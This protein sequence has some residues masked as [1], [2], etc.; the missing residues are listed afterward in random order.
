MMARIGY[1]AMARRVRLAEAVL[2]FIV[3][4]GAVVVGRTMVAGPLFAGAYT[5]SVDLPAA[6]G[7]HEHADVSYRG[8]HIGTVTAVKLTPTGVRATLHI[9]NDIPIPRDSDVVVSN[10]S[11]VGEQYVDFRPRTASGPYLADGS[12][13]RGGNASL[14]VPTWQVLAHSQRLLSQV[15]TDDLAT[16]THEVNAIFGSG[17]ADLPGLLDEVERT[18]DMLENLTPSVLQLVNEGEK[19]LATMDDLSPEIRTLMKNSRKITHQLSQSNPTIKKLINQGSVL[20]PVLVKDF[21]SVSPVL[22]RMLDDGTPVAAMAKAHLPGL[23]HWYEWGPKQL[24][25][26]ADATRDKSAHV[27]LVV[28]FADNC[29]YGPEVSPFQE[30]ADLPLSARCTTVDPHIQ[31]R[32]SQYAPHPD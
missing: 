4:V 13:I 24:V 22:V 14:P 20:I 29:H 11:A 8:Q 2:A 16:I 30:K 26:M 32:G 28:T 23:L 15:N 12:T 6:A 7:L 31:Q 5:V 27:I 1:Q 9:E 10:L 19:P 17:D 25:A 3:I 18:L 21:D